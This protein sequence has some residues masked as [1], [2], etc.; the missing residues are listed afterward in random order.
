[1]VLGAVALAALAPHLPEQFPAENRQMADVVAALQ[2]FRGVVRLEMPGHGA[3]DIPAEQR[4]V[5]VQKTRAGLLGG[6]AGPVDGVGSQQIVVVGQSQILPVGQL[7]RLVGV[8]RNALVFDLFIPDAAVLFRRLP[9]PLA[10]LGVG[11][12]AGV[13]QAELPPGAGLALDAGQQLV[14][15]Q[16]GGI[17]QGHADRD[18]RPIVGVGSPLGSQGLFG[19]QKTALFAEKPPFYKGAGAFYGGYNAFLF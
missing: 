13:G 6:A 19:G 11:L 12:V 17:V 16:L 4:L 15:I 3:A 9:G 2:I 7:G 10:H 1:M 18:H 8:G 14:K 5:A